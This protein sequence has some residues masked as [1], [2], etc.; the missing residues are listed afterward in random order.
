MTH[1]ERHRF[2]TDQRHRCFN[3]ALDISEAIA[4]TILHAIDNGLGRI[5]FAVT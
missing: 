5:N 2:L 3:R 1:A 4:K